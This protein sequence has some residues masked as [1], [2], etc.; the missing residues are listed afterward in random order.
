MVKM[1][2]MLVRSEQ[3][4]LRSKNGTAERVTT[5]LS[6]DLRLSA[7]LRGNTIDGGDNLMARMTREE[8]LKTV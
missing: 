4:I 8:I 6:G 1:V 7:K 2:S 3:T 5:R